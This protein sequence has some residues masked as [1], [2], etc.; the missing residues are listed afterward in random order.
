PDRQR[1]VHS[2]ILGAVPG[3]ERPGTLT[4]GRQAVNAQ[5][6]QPRDSED[7]AFLAHTLLRLAA[8]VAAVDAG[9]LLRPGVSEGE[10]SAP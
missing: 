1:T 4:K 9:L 3:R 2:L 7:A 8:G 6:A 5:S 10:T